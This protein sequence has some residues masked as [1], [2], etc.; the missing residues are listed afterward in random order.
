MIATLAN[1]RTFMSLVGKQELTFEEAY[2]KVFKL[3]NKV[4]FLPIGVVFVMENQIN[5][6]VIE[7]DLI[8]IILENLKRTIEVQDLILEDECCIFKPIYC[9][10]DVSEK[11]DVEG[12]KANLHIIY[13][14]KSEEGFEM[15]ECYI[16]YKKTTD[17]VSFIVKQDGFYEKTIPVK[18]DLLVKE[19]MLIY[20]K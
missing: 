16:H 14:D 4:T 19:L 8:P 9:H 1:L 17:E 12:G 6:M 2:N 5:S 11:M 15:T 20:S 3:Q 10:Y 13:F 7:R 18:V